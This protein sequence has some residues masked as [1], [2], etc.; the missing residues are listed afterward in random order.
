GALLL[1]AIIGSTLYLVYET[2]K[3]S[4]GS[5]AARK[6]R[7]AAADLLLT[8]QDAESSQ[9]GYLLTSDEKF[10]MPYRQ[11]SADMLAKELT[12]EAAI[13]GNPFIKVDVPQIQKLISNKVAELQ[14]T[15]DL[16]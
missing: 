9:R 11:A 10:L 6:V 12:F 1:V 15:I 7:S 14:Q 3:Y 8:V 2:Q 16:V 4:E 5:V 13:A